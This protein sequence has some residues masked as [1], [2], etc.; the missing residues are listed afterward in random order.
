[1]KYAKSIILAVFILLLIQ[2]PAFAEDICVSEESAR[3]IVSDLE[4]IPTITE[5]LN[6]QKQLNSELE[7]TNKLLQEKI[8]LKDKEIVAKDKAIADLNNLIATQKKDYE[9]AIDEVKPSMFGNLLKVL[10]GVGIG[11]LVGVLLL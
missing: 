4:S 3:K 7:K 2:L 10:G 1:L 11:I 9:K 8:D 6:L 5:K